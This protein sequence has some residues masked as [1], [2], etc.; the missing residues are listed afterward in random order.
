MNRSAAKLSA[1]LAGDKEITSDMAL[2]LEKVVGVPAHNWTGLEAEYRLALARLQ[3]A[4]TT[5]RRK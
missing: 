4:P 3:E 5:T 1:I 2:Q